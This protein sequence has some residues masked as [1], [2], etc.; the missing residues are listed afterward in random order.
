MIEILE[1]MILDRDFKII[2]FN[3]IQ[4][5]DNKRIKKSL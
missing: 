4:N 3:I 5:Y 2:I 1:I